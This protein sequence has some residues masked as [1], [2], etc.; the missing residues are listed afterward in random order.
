MDNIVEVGEL[1]RRQAAIEHQLMNTAG[2][3]VAVEWLLTTTRR[4]L[5][6]YPEALAAVL[7][8]ARVLPRSSDT[9]ANNPSTTRQWPMP[10]LGFWLE[11]MVALGGRQ[12]TY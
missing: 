6:D 11:S 12:T 5:V 1:L 9:G 2:P 4:R 7:H 10:A 8:T 3:A